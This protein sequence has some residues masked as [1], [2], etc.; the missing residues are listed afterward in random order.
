VADPSLDPGTGDDT[1]GVGSH[2][3]ATSGMP[4]WVK[5]FLIVAL[6]VVLLLIILLLTSGGHGPGRHMSGGVGGPADANEAARTVEVTTLDTMTFEPSEID[7]SAGETVTFVVTNTGQEVHEFTLGN[8]A[9]QQEHA[10]AMAHMPA[11]MAHET[12]NSITL[13]P[14]ETEQLTWRFGDTATLE[15]VCHQPD[16]YQAGMRGGVTIT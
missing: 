3:G 8:A 11:G 10:E 15:Y 13:Q 9:M 4:R 2:R 1:G 16:H 5:T 12:P 6:V 14:G 7:V